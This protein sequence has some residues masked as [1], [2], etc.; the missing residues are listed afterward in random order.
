[1][2][3]DVK[4]TIEQRPDD[5]SWSLHDKKLSIRNNANII[6]SNLRTDRDV[7]TL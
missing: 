4:P 3:C 7:A 6:I 1:M 5:V 2:K